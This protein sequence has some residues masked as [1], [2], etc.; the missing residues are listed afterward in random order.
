[1]RKA[2]VI[3]FLLLS[4]TL[5]ARVRWVTPR[6]NDSNTG[7]DS[8][9]TGAWATWG[10]AFQTAIAGDTV[11]IRG[12]VYYVTASGQYGDITNDGTEGSYINFWAYPNDWDNGNYPILDFGRYVAPDWTWAIDCYHD[13]YLYFKGLTIRNL[14]QNPSGGYVQGIEIEESHHVILENLNVHHIGG[15]CIS[16]HG[17]DEVYI[18]NTDTW[19]SCDSLATNPGQNGTGIGVGTRRSYIYAGDPYDFHVYIEGCRAWN[20]SDQGFAQSGV[21]Y[22][23]WKNNWSFNNGRFNGE[24]WGMKMTISTESDTINPLSRVVKNCIFAVNASSGIDP[25]NLGGSNFNGHY[26][27]NF[28]YHHGYKPETPYYANEY[29]GC[30]IW[31]PNYIGTTPAPNELYANNLSYD[32][33]KGDVVAH[34]AYTHEYNSWEVATGVTVTDDDFISLDT[35]ELLYP[36][37]SDWSLPD[38][39]FGKLAPTSDLIDAGIDSINTRDY[40][41]ALDYYGD[42]P[43]LGWHEYSPGPQIIA[44]H[45]I[46]DDY[47][48][49]PQYYIDSVKKMW[50][51]YAGESHSGAIRDGLQALENL[52]PTYAVA[53]A[54]SGTPASYTDANLRASRATW[55]DLTNST[56]WIYSYGEEDWYTSSTAITRTKAGLD[57]YNNTG[58]EMAAFGFGWCWDPLEILEDMDD[59]IAATQQYIDH[60][61][62]NGYLTKVFFTTGP[63]D[64]ETATGEVGYNK[65]LAYENIRDSVDA[66]TTRILFD[67]ADILSYDEVDGDPN[68]ATWDGHTYPIITSANATPV[69]GTYHFSATGALR[70]AKAMWWMLAR[71]AGWDGNVTVYS[72]QEVD[73]TATDILTFTL[74]DQTGAATINATNHTVAIEV[75]YTA[76]ITALAPTIT[77]SHG[78]TIIPAS[79]TARDFTSPVPYTVTALDGTTTQAWVVTVT[80]EEEPAAPAGDSSIVKYRGLIFKL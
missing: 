26:I 27:N 3:L 72:E 39:N 13:N 78:A 2:L 19:E 60:C 16:S 69:T 46:V 33:E 14:V 22:H 15:P 45:S 44:D 62:T 29:I 41:I 79:G 30:A 53:I 74:A 63:V 75:D 49:I 68:T 21:G 66:D 32:N 24:G 61:E 36:R 58:P 52:N 10:K 18:K 57:Y 80:Q 8:S 23:E 67:F 42:A 17:S 51:S 9:S 31:I 73:S 65:Y 70:L 6:G 28:F 20:C 55:G 37:K 56:G 54:S 34:D 12:G 4:I 25:N 1:M 11:Y 7:A 64:G 47:E 76:D 77:L 43:D 5:D 50:L 40:A 38:I 59:Y 35:L 71:M 48:H